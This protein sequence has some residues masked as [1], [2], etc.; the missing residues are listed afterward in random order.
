[1][2]VDSTIHEVYFGIDVGGTTIKMG[3]FDGEKNLLDKWEIPTRKGEEDGLLADICMAME[4][5]LELNALKTRDVLGIGIGIPGPVTADGTVLDCVNLGWGQVQLAQKLSAMFDGRPVMAGNDA[6]VAALGEAYHGG[7]KGYSDVLMVTLGTG[8]GGGV[9]IGGKM[10]AGSN[11][12]AGEIG[13]M[14]VW[15]NEACCNC[16]KNDCLELV[17]SATGIVRE[18]SYVMRDTKLSSELRMM[19]QFSAKKVLDLAQVMDEVAIETAHRAAKAL[20]LAIACVAATVNP[21]M[22]LIGG[23]VSRTGQWFV[24]MISDE[25]NK[26]AFYNCRNAKF[27]LATLGNDAG[28]FGA[29]ELAVEVSKATK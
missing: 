23:G 22:I 9:I 20:G 19:P 13:H 7:A 12:A 18:A 25:F 17:A 26:K 6:N 2:A 3:A 10:V 8:V 21:E 14:P 5:F 15:E 1:M 11:G 24:D 27:A 28:I 4:D 29:L 16:G